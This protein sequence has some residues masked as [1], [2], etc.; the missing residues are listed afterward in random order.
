ASGEA[1]CSRTSRARVRRSNSGAG[2]L[3]SLRSK[4]PARRRRT[5]AEES[6]DSSAHLLGDRPSRRRIL[7]LDRG[8]LVPQIG[9]LAGH[10]FRFERLPGLFQYPENL[11]RAQ[12]AALH[13][14]GQH[15]GDGVVAGKWAKARLDSGGRARLVAAPDIEDLVLVQIDLFQQSLRAN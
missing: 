8:D 12:M 15:I 10:G 5:S 4:R 2:I 11:H 14:L 3:L 7:R 6:I 13:I 9:A 1:M